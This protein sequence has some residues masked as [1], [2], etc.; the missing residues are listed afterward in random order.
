MVYDGGA[1]DRVFGVAT[2]LLRAGRAVDRIP[3][4]MRFFVPVQTGP[5]FYNGTVVPGCFPPVVP[6]RGVDDS[7]AASTKDELERMWK[8][9]IVV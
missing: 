5:K 6:G 2:C 7:H 3:A 4:G 9:A 1:L 8:E